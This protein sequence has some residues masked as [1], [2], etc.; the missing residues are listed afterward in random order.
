MITDPSLGLA[1]NAGVGSPDE[2]YVEVSRLGI[3][4]WL[5]ADFEETEHGSAAEL[6]SRGHAMDVVEFL[7]QI[8]EFAKKRL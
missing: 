3:G 5:R 6:S 8:E 4:V 2:L 7:G 1:T